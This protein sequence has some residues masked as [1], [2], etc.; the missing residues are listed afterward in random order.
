MTHAD[1]ERPR[2][3]DARPQ[4]IDP[5]GG[6]RNVAP[7]RNRGRWLWAAAAV[8]VILLLLVLAFW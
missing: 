4:V 2:P 8:F 7:Q 5:R 3:D 1:N 6:T